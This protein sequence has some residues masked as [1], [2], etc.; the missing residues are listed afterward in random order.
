MVSFSAESLSQLRSDIKCRSP[1]DLYIKEHCTFI[2]PLQKLGNDRDV[3]IDNINS[4]S[5]C[6]RT[7][8]SIFNGIIVGSTSRR[9]TEHRMNNPLPAALCL[10]YRTPSKLCSQGGEGPTDNG[11]IHCR[12]LIHFCI[13]FHSALGMKRGG[14]GDGL[15]KKWHAF[16]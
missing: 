15:W 1:T 2:M 9:H 13:T 3:F 14:W 12:T 10:I 4:V 16:V 8:I 6:M 7:A 11:L 5:L